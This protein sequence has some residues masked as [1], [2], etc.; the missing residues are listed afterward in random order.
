VTWRGLLAIRRVRLV[1]AALVASGWADGFLPVALSFAVLRITGSVAR[2]GLVLAVQGGVALLLTLA[3]GLAGD[4]FP[5]RRIMVVSLATRTVVAAVIAATLLAGVASFPLLLA[6]AG[7]YGCA[8]GFFGPASSALL[9]EIV[10]RQHLAPANALIGGTSSAASVAAPAIAGAIVA[11]LGTGAAFAV[12]AGAL[13]I[14]LGCLIMVQIPASPLAQTCAVRVIQ[15]LRLGWAEF[16]KRRW[17]WLLTVEWTVFSLVVLAPVNVLG[18]AIAQR[19]LG[20]ASA[21]GIIG[22][23]LSLGAIAGQAM[24]GHARMPARPALVIACLVPLMTGEALVLGLGLPLAVVA[25]TTA[26]SGLAI[27][28][29]AVIFPTAMQLS[30]PPDVLARVTSIDLLTSEGGQP[31]GYVLAGPVGAAVGPHDYLAS[32][33]IG[34]IAASL[35]Y[36]LL[37]ALRVRVI[38]RKPSQT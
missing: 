12:Q 16:A 27:G 30:V 23:C 1:T 22:S 29:Q 2:L 17:L 6:M 5:R 33:A 37:P 35:A 36:A 25:L 32:A 18:P 21:W 11:T 38:A 34:I 13:A 31:A 14:A 24:A 15:Q 9:P 7:V 10:P 28:V 8:D 26:V 19:Y 4:R 20:G 3:G